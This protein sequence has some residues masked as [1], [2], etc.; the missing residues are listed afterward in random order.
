MP[1][2]KAFL[3]MNPEE[4]GRA[5]QTIPALQRQQDTHWETVAERTMASVHQAVMPYV[6]GPEGKIDQFNEEQKEELAV[7]FR[8]WCLRDKTGARVRRYE[9]G[10]PKLVEDFRDYYAT[11]HH[12]PAHRANV[13]AAAGR[14]AA[15]Q[16]APRAGKADVTGTPVPK[17]DATDEDA[18]HG[19]GWQHV[20]NA[21]RTS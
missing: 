15:G 17:V 2:L 4:L 6:L 19:A 8:N 12:A 16:S 13:A 5:M 10:D 9:G 21:L 18:V 1:E 3:K 7:S 11:T 14:V 20:R